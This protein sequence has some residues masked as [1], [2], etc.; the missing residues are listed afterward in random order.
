MESTVFSTSYFP[1]LKHCSGLVKADRILLDYGE[2]F[3]KQTGRNRCYVK[4][5]NGIL[6]LIVPL[7][8]WKNNTPVRDIRISYIENW[9]KLHWKTLESCYRS[10]PYFEFY[11][12]KFKTVVVDSK[13]EFLVDLNFKTLELLTDVL[14]EPLKISTSDKYITQV[15]QNLDYRN[16]DFNPRY[17]SG[18]K[19]YIQVF[20][21][22]QFTDN[23]SFIDLI[24]NE[25]PNAIH[26]LES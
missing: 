20:D 13:C 10:S 18:S 7:E 14:K 3:V 2:H 24:C 5:P 16:T 8:K 19:T 26:L 9:Q 23:L 4:G 25:G 21:P 15:Q 22:D 12:M 1:C 6:K 17:F 11:E